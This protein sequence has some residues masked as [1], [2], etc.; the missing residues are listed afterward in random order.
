MKMLKRR[1]QRKA[2]NHERVLMHDQFTKELVVELRN[3]KLY[4]T[5]MPSYG[6]Y[7]SMFFD[8]VMKHRA[9]ERY[10]DLLKKC[11]QTDSRFLK[12]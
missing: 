4:N 9:Y 10:K 7:Q 2:W 12:R 1:R 6:E 11:G 5:V 3:T 8:F